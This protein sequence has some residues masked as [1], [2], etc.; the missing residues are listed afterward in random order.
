MKIDAFLKDAGW[1]QRGDTWAA[2]GRAYRVVE[3][4]APGSWD[5]SVAAFLAKA[6]LHARAGAPAEA[7]TVAVLN[8][9]RASALTDERLSKFVQEVAPEQ[10]WVLADADGR[11]FP[12]VKSAPELV[13]AAAKQ[14]VPG[15][16]APATPKQPSLFTDLNQWMLKVLLAPS[17]PQKYISAPSG[18]TPRNATTLAESA[19]VS[20]AAA[21]RFLHALEAE[22]QLDTQYGDLRVARPLDLLKQWRDRLGPTARRELAAAGVRG[23]FDLHLTAIVA[24]VY[25][26]AERKRPPFVLGLHAACAELGLGHVSGAVPVVWAPSLGAADLERHGLVVVT[27]DQKADVVLREPRYPESLYRGVVSGGRMPATDVI[28]CWLDTSHYRIRG[29]EQADFLW[30]TVL[31]PAFDHGPAQR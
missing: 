11:I 23:P 24:G 30:R 1:R 27:A 3:E 8:V 15:A 12:H 7:E 29:E 20:V 31:R 13:R 19:G 26:G 6:I 14:R 4:A 16:A 28:Q 2:D 22:G 21:V 5:R 18:R 17:L 10:S 9:K 25:A